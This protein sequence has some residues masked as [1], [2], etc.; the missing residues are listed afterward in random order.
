[1]TISRRDFLRLSG[2]AA[3]GLGIG[4]SISWAGLRPVYA[5]DTAPAMHVLN[6]LTWGV[7]PADITRINQ[8]GIEQYIDWQ[9]QPDHIPDPVI[10]Q[11]VKDTPYL[12]MS[13]AELNGLGMKA[14]YEKVLPTM[15]WARVFRAVH[16][17]RQLHELMVEFWTDHFN[18][19]IP[20]L[21][22]EKVVD[23]R[24][25]IRKH[26][27]GHFRDLLFASAQ[28]A[29]MLLYLDNAAS[30]KAHPNEN[31]A[32]ELMEL[33]TLGVDGGYTEKD[34]KEVARALTG[35]TVYQDGSGRFRFDENAHD[36]GAKTVLGHSLTA[37]RNVEDGLETLDILATHPSTAHHIC[38]KLVR[39]FVSDA[40]LPALVAS[41][42]Q[43]FTST[44]GDIR[45]VLRHILT[46]AE[47]M[48]AQGKKLRRPLD[49]LVALMRITG[50]T[51][52]K[53]EVAYYLLEQMGQVPFFW[54]PPNGYPD[55]AAAWINTSGLLARWNVAMNVMY[56]SDIGMFGIHVPVDRLFPG[57]KSVGALVDAAIDRV[58]GGS[59]AEA[60]REQLIRFV[61]EGGKASDPITG[62]IRTARIS[63][64]IGLLMAS[65]YFQWH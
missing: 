33:H 46:S 43:V 64:L 17:E 23:D 16:T 58:L 18:V 15:I 54:H 48:Q 61:A 62:H 45:K 1:M 7:R 8:I 5:S 44:D 34:V 56:A 6:R 20:E 32:R 40:P 28:S 65:P 53:P 24:E 14:M 30:H 49:F 3:A 38:R 55:A 37:G 27:L 39:R 22:A 9:L 35:W 19:A 12:S 11:F 42:A 60:D 31:Y 4:G 21:V 10:D 63:T 41:A 57:V 47:F 13:L 2:V 29:A 36:Q 52:E 26:A 25:V 51:F 59:I 50:A